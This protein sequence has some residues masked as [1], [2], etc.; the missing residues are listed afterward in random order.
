MSLIHWWPLNG[1]LKDYGLLNTTLTNLNSTAINNNGKIGK[2]YYFNGSN[3]AL[4]AEY[5]N[6]TKPTT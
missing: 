6:T 4:R 2:C 5:P 3:N 1:N